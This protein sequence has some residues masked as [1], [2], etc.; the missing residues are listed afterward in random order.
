MPT[1]EELTAAVEKYAA[2]HTAGDIDGIVALFAD[3]A[4]VADPV[5][6]PEHV[7]TEAIR[8]FFAG[9]HQLADSLE[10][11]ITGPIRAVDRFAAVPLQA[12]TTLGDQKFVIDIIDV[13]TMNDDGKFSE[14][15]AYWSSGAIRPFDG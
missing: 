13:F 7:G 11:L 2:S 8:T 10:L 15:R 9:T 5:D 4:V 14:M 1:T 6:Q 3:D 12:V